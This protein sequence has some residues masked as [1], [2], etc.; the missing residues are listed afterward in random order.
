[1]LLRGGTIVAGF[2]GGNRA[3]A[4]MFERVCRGVSNCCIRRIV[5][6]LVKILERQ[7]A[8]KS[9]LSTTVVH[10]DVALTDTLFSSLTGHDHG[11]ANFEI[12]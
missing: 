12:K 3:L 10:T 2:R 6:G 9:C 1:M 7:L 5:F 4:E 8:A 11:D